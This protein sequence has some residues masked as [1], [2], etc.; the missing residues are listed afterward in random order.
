M[1]NGYVDCFSA[2]C[3]FCRDLWKKLDC[4]FVVVFIHHFLKINEYSSK[5]TGNRVNKIN[6]AK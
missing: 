1:A 4:D 5:N 3:F 6:M 2:V